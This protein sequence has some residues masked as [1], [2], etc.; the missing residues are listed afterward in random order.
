MR[1]DFASRRTSLSEGATEMDELGR[2]LDE[3]RLRASS[4]VASKLYVLLDLE[5]IRD[6]RVVPF[7][8]TVLGDRH[9]AERVRIHV[10]KQLRNG[11]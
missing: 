3:Y 7:L 2:L 5:R 6:P 10:L 8:L 9:E 4:S 1:A 11:D